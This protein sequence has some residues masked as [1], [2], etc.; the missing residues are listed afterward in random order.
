MAGCP[1]M[2]TRHNTPAASN[3]NNP[4]Y[5]ITAA[6]LRGFIVGVTQEGS[7]LTQPTVTYGTVSMIHIDGIAVGDATDQRVD[8]F[9][10]NDAGIESASTAVVSVSGMAT[11][12]TL[13]MA[14]YDNCVQTTPTVTDTHAVTGAGTTVLNFTT[15]DDSVAV[16]LGG[17]G[18][19]GTVSWSGGVT[20]HTEQTDAS[21]TATGS[22]ADEEVVTGAAETYT[23]TWTTANRRAGVGCVLA[24]AVGITS[25]VPSEFDMDNADV[26]I[27]GVSFGATIGASDVYLSPNDLLSEAGEVDITTAVNTWADTVIN[28]DL[29]LLSASVLT[30]LHTMGPGARFIIVNVGGVPGTT[31]FFSAITL[32][33]PHAFQMVLSANFAPGAT[34][35]RITGMTGTF[36]GGRIEE[37]LNPST[38]DTNIADD[39]QREDVW[40]IEGKTLARDVAYVFRTLYDGNVADTITQTPQVTISSSGTINSKTLTDTL[41]VTDPKDILRERNREQLDSAETIDTL[42]ALRESYRV[43]LDTLAA[44]DASA[45]SIARGKILSDNI[46][47]ID[48]QIA[49]KIQGRELLDTAVVTDA[50]AKL[51]ERNRIQTDDLAMDYSL[52]TIRKRMVTI[53]NNVVTVTDAL[54]AEKTAAPAVV[55]TTDSVVVGDTLEILRERSR[56]LTESIAIIDTFV[57]LRERNRVLTDSISVTD[58]AII[59]IIGTVL[60]DSVTATDAIALYREANRASTEAMAIVDAHVELRKRNRVLLDTVAVVDNKIATLIQAGNVTS[61]TQTE[62]IA[63]SDFLVSLRE[64]NRVVLETVAGTDSHIELRERNRT[65]QDTITAI[66]FDVELRER[67]RTLFDDLASIDIRVALRER[68]RILLDTVTVTDSIIVTT[69]GTIARTLL[70]AIAVTDSDIELRQRFR[71]L[72]DT[73]SVTDLAIIPSIVTILFDSIDVTDVIELFRV[74]GRG[75][76]D[77]AVLTDAVFATYIPEGLIVQLR[78]TT[79]IFDVNDFIDAQ[80]IFG[81]S[82]FAITHGIDVLEVDHTVENLNIINHIEIDSP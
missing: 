18:N 64:R 41:V 72:L 73:I 44:T 39:G 68:N 13:H 75:L 5:T 55:V 10:L 47:T 42:V 26:D 3:T 59:P 20:E 30:D 58:L 19:S 25:V 48:A 70:D 52:E 80:K 76:S 38:T 11:A 9:W 33:R 43:Q 57:A 65:L 15:S 71:V 53:L 36:G 77:D 69:L 61:R 49:I 50:D 23:A 67:N 37:A 79:D 34:T 8:M 54:V 81:M 1:L 6:T 56:L 21:P 62:S 32:H 82:D 45:Q 24:D 29:T 63:I 46:A 14:S 31:E 22:L 66:D 17:M 78:T 27:N 60:F 35:N 28:L 51:R 40:N 74:S 7:S 12:F 2:A 16:C 4:T